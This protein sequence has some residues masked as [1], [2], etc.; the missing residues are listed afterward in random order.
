MF[1]GEKLYGRHLTVPLRELIQNAADA[2]GYRRELEPP[3]SMYDGN[4]TVRLTK[5]SDSEDWLLSVDDDGL[6]MSQAVLTGPLIDFGSSYM[7]SALVKAERPGLLSKGR[8]RIGEFGVGF[9]SAFMIADHVSV[10]SK[11]FDQGLDSCRT[12]RFQNGIVSRP[13]LLR[14]VPSGFGASLSSRVT[15]RITS[16]KLN[17]LLKTGHALQPDSGVSISIEQL[18]PLLCPMLDAN[19]YVVSGGTTTLAHERNWMDSDR[20]AWLSRI[21]HPDRHSD[22]SYEDQ[23]REAAPRLTFI[24]PDDPSSGLACIAFNAGA[25]VSTVGSLQATP[26]FNAYRNEYWGAIDYLPSGPQ[27]SAGRPRKSESLR[28]WATEQAK[29]LEHSTVEFPERQYAAQRV[30]AFGGDSTPIV[31]MKLNQEWVTLDAV[32]DYLT[33][34]VTVY[35]PLKPG[36]GHGS[37]NKTLITVVRENHSGWIDNYLPGDL[38][39][40]VPTLEGFGSSGDDDLY[41]VP[42]DA[43]PAEVGFCAL[44]SRR[45]AMRGILING[46]LIERVDFARYIGEASRRDNLVPG[47]LIGGW[48]LQLSATAAP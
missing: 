39:Y 46:A 42:T 20:F 13:L 14:E 25:G 15:L 28:K 32:L 44:L 41:R 47:K 1:G 36:F 23:M 26:F 16:E 11:P 4:I 48:A 37:E 2:I 10:T 18:V 45:A 3:G 22:S 27:R 34:G 30:A 24:D 12:L 43:D 7:S 29:L 33:G 6:G 17:E 40:L 31:G 5:S 35:A 9:F 38:E 8:R 21:A 19:V